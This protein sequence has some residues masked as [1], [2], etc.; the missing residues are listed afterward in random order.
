MRTYR[1][2]MGHPNASL[3]HCRAVCQQIRSTQGKALPPSLGFPMADA[4]TEMVP[5]QSNQLVG[6]SNGRGVY[7]LVGG[8]EAVP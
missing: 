8:R 4:L 3:E 1:N 5:L 6:L 7:L 2:K